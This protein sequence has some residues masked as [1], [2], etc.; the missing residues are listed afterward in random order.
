MKACGLFTTVYSYVISY[1]THGLVGVLVHAT[2]ITGDLHNRYSEKV[3]VASACMGERATPR[4]AP[5]ARGDAPHIRRPLG[6]SLSLPF[7]LQ[8]C[9]LCRLAAAAATAAAAA[10]TEMD[11]PRASNFVFRIARLGVSGALH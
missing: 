5:R 8:L 7:L 1:S 2:S 6:I 4:R 3:R 10:R 9:P 11:A